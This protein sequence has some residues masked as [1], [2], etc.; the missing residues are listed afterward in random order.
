MLESSCN[1]TNS[2]PTVNNIGLVL[3]CNSCGQSFRATVCAQY[4][5][6]ESSGHSSMYTYSEQILKAVEI[7]KDLTQDEELFQ[8]YSTIVN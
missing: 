6:E 7:R 3:I 4:R 2:R 1:S 5:G 8:T